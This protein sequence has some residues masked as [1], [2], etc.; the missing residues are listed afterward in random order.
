MAG[1]LIALFAFEQGRH[2]VS[3]LSE[4]HYRLVPPEALTAEELRRYAAR[5]A[6]AWEP[7]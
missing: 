3:I 6:E 7:A 4:K 2:G 5:P 1:D